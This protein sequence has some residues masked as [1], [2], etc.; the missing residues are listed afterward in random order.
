MPVNRPSAQLDARHWQ[1]L[2][3]L[4]AASFSAGYDAR[5]VTVAL[6]QIRASYHLSLA[7]AS[8]ARG[9]GFGRLAMLSALGTGWAAILYAVILHPAGISWGA[10]PWRSADPRAACPSRAVVLLAIG[11][12]A[13]AVL[14]ATRFP[15][16]GGRE[17]EAI[18]AELGS[19]DAG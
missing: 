14:I 6:P 5:I 15:E 8:R 10:V 9:F 18:A 19:T 3:L 4:G 11:P 13:A 2:W 1:T 7:T 17:L 16:T 12:L